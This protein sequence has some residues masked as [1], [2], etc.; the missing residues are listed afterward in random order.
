VDGQVTRRPTLSRRPRQ[1][2]SRKR[3]RG[4]TRGALLSELPGVTRR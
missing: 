2:A 1:E 4:R 3:L